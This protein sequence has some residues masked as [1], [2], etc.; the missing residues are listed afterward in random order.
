MKVKL[1]T[2]QEEK[3]WKEVK[4][5]GILIPKEEFVEID[6]KRGYDWLKIQMTQRVEKPKK[7]K[8]YP[9]WAWFQHENQ[10][11]RRPDLRKTGSLPSG[12]V[13]YRIEIEKDLKD[14]LLSDFELWH[15]VLNEWCFVLSEEDDEKFEKEKKNKSHEYIKSRME[16]SWEKIFDMDFHLKDYALPF[17]EKSIQATFWELKL[18]EV[19]KVDKFIA[20]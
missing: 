14:I 2:I 5:K 10:N 3:G 15:Y 1:W 17:Q 13:G 20:R 11:K 16:K 4:T 6:F 12:T 8:Q 19:I 18:E 7:N 9:V